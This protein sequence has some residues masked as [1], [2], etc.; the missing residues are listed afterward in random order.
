MVNGVPGTPPESENIET[1]RPPPPLGPCQRVNLMS[2]MSKPWGPV[3]KPWARSPRPTEG[4]SILGPINGLGLPSVLTTSFW[5]CTLG[6]MKTLAKQTLHD[7]I[8]K[9]IF[10]WV[11]SFI[12]RETLAAYFFV[13]QLRRTT[14]FTTSWNNQVESPTAARSNDRAHSGRAS[15]ARHATM[16]DARHR[17]QHGG[18]AYL[19]P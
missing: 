15:D 8:N 5:P 6:P 1:V 2:P 12:I 13:L 18:S 16:A 10:L 14:Y 4:S 17:V 7:T 19:L 11:R 9:G 3:A